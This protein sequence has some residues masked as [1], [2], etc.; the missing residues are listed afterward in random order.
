MITTIKCPQCGMPLTFD[1]AVRSVQMRTCPKCSQQFTVEFRPDFRVETLLGQ[2][3]TDEER[4]FLDERK[5]LQ[6]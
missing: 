6:F 4:E 3:A 5:I 2:I 1:D